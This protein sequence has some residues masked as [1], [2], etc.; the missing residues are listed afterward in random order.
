MKA[1][2]NI[3]SNKNENIQRL[4]CVAHTLQL[5]VIKAL[6]SISKQVKRYRKLVKFFQSPKQSE[7]LQ[8]VQKELSKKS[9]TYNEN[10]NNEDSNNDLFEPSNVNILKNINEVPTR[11]NSKYNSWK[12][13]IELKRPIIRLNAT[14]HLEENR[15][16]KLDG[17]RLQKIMLCEEEWILLEE[18]CSLFKPFDEVTTYFSGVE[19][20]TI[21]S[22]LPIIHTMKNLFSKKL[23]DKYKINSE[24]LTSNTND[25]D[26]GKFNIIIYL[27]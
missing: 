19:Y 15:I 14:L 5:T 9:Q 23:K 16:D 26:T 17:E 2:I 3:L 21:S 6:K 25:N 12:R 4:P 8:E 11:W 20:A 1:A 27:F 7:R 24:N 18:L 13:L 10:S 22:I